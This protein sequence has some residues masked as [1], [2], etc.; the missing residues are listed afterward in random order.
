MC[1]YPPL[2]P[3]RKL[4]ILYRSPNRHVKWDGNHFPSNL[5]LDSSCSDIS[6]G[7]LHFDQLFVVITTLFHLKQNTWSSS[8]LTCLA[9]DEDHFD[10][11]PRLNR[12]LP[13]EKP[14][15]P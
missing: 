7:L 14:R 1:Y 9:S 2:F 3:L 8:T 11:E 13:D 5:Y 10:L 12:L 15:H 4:S 6:H